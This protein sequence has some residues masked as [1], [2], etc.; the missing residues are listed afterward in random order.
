MI[1]DRIRVSFDAP[2]GEPPASNSAQHKGRDLHIQ[3]C[4]PSLT[5]VAQVRSRGDLLAIIDRV[6][7][8]QA[9]RGELSSE[10]GWYAELLQKR[11]AEEGDAY[12]R[13]WM[14]LESRYD[15]KLLRVA[16]SILNDLPE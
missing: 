12:I 5:E 13:W 9:S 11:Q 3:H 7:Y 6:E 8:C 4:H 15:V 2:V 1:I 10:R 16:R 14:E